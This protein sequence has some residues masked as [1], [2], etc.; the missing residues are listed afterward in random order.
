MTAYALTPLL[1][2]L[3]EGDGV[4]KVFVDWRR[5]AGPEFRA[6]F[7]TGAQAGYPE[8]RERSR[9]LAERNANALR[10]EILASYPQGVYAPV[11]I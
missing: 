7:P 2:T 4:L 11:W 1:V 8:A 3:E 5:G 9:A 10:D 6:S